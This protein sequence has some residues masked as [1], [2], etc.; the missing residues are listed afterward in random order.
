MMSLD[1][2]D[3][4]TRPMSL[5]VLCSCFAGVPQCLVE[6]GEL[7]LEVANQGQGQGHAIAVQ[8][9]INT[10]PRSD[11]DNG[12]GC[13]TARSLQYAVYVLALVYLARG[14]IGIV[15]SSNFNAHAL[16]NSLQLIVDP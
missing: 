3:Q 7:T 4:P 15:L 16:K 9:G 12:L 13:I 6:R 1:H 11:E 14:I 5:C 10:L 2:R 8:S